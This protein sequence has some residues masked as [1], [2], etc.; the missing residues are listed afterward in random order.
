MMVEHKAHSISHVLKKFELKKYGFQ[1]PIHYQRGY[2]FP[3]GSR[4]TVIEEALD[5]IVVES[6]TRLME[7]CWKR[8]VHCSSSHIHMEAMTYMD[9]YWVRG[10]FLLVPR[11]EK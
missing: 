11:E 2:D 7:G 10:L 3:L 5:L 6:S 8:L 4:C 9:E 1:E